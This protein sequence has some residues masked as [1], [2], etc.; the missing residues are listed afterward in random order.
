MRGSPPEHILQGPLAYLKIPAQGI[1]HVPQFDLNCPIPLTHLRLQDAHDGWHLVQRAYHKPPKFRRELNA[2]LQS[3]RNVTFI[4]QAEKRS[5]PD[6]DEWYAEQQKM[7][8]QRPVMK[9]AVESRNHVVKQGDLE[10]RSISTARVVATYLDPESHEAEE[11]AEESSFPPAQDLR[12]NAQVLRDVLSSLP[13]GIIRDGYLELR[14][15]WVDRALPDREILDACGE[16][17]GV[18]GSI[19]DDLHRRMGL[20]CATPFVH[21]GSAYYISDVPNERLPCMVAPDLDVM[22]IRLSGGDTS[23]GGGRFVIPPDHRTA[24]VARK[25]YG[26]HAPL[27]TSAVANVADMADWYMEQARIIMRKDKHHGLFAFLFVGTR[28]VGTEVLMVTD[29]A[30]KLALMRELADVIERSGIDGVIIV[31]DAWMSPIALDEDGII[32]RAKDHPQRKEAL[33]VTAEDAY[34]HRKTLLSFYERKWG[35]PTFIG[36]S[37]EMDN[38]AEEGSLAPIRK[39]WSR[40]ELREPG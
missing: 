2:L 37:V 7:M 14:R 17:H 31:G 35:R 32:R 9:W 13:E 40:R 21:E 1:S 12:N 24:A 28:V 10:T 3:L 34:G 38:T 29:Q 23:V 20:T 19:V 18:L 25:R 16:V 26:Q 4:L 6:F 27:D 39:V 36:E 5:I 8:R 22:R 15:R 33:T 11:G 30:D